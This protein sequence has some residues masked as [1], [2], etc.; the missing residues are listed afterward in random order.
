MAEAARAS[1]T[2]RRRFLASRLEHARAFVVEPPEEPGDLVVR[3][4]AHARGFLHRVGDDLIATVAGV[5]LRFARDAVAALTSASAST[6]AGFGLRGPEVLGGERGGR[7]AGVEASLFEDARH[8]GVCLGRRRAAVSSTTAACASARIAAV[9]S[10][11]TA[12]TA[13]RMCAAVASAVTSSSCAVSRACRSVA[14]A[15]RRSRLICFFGLPP[16][17]ALVWFPM[18]DQGYGLSG[19]RTRIRRN[20][21]AACVS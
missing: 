5:G 21:C 18:V 3:G 1:A 12:Y 6:D 4:A 2:T 16:L 14:M 7:G 20:R 9:S 17:P 8:L 11:A 10:A 13:S 19:R 15:S